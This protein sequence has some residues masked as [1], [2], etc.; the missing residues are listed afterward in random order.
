MARRYSPLEYPVTIRQVGGHL[1]LSVKDLHITIAEEIPPG[2]RI[3]PEFLKRTT[4]ALAKAWVKSNERL[5]TLQEAGKAHP[6]PSNIRVATDEIKKQK[7]L[8]APE[9]AKLLGRSENT[10]RRIPKAE[11]NYRKTKGGHRK[12][13]IGAV[14]AY[15]EQYGLDVKQEENKVVIDGVEFE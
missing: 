13:S 4:A 11:L 15:A 9:V 5:K 2:G 6:E 8:T 14:Y 1:I 3:T 7:P 10:V 12:Y